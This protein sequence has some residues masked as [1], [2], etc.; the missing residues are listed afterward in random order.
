MFNNNIIIINNSYIQ[1][2][3]TRLEEGMDICA[4]LSKTLLTLKQ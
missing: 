1:E 2:E 4:Q 3:S